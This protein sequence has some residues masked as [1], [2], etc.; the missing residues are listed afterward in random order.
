M[1]VDAAFSP[2]GGL[3]L[4]TGA[5]GVVRLWRTATG[6]QAAALGVP[7]HRVLDAAFGPRGTFV[8]TTS[9]DSTARLWKTS[10]GKEVASLHVP[11]A[12]LLAAT[13][14][15]ERDPSLPKFRALAARLGIYLH[16]GSRR[17]APAKTEPPAGCPLAL[18]G[19]C[20]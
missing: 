12:R 16:I 17:R 4:T 10:T 6:R 14:S 5:D 11:R 1:P 13:E 18:T 9:D 19:G 7:G 20:R 3:L 15:E 8:V 2:D